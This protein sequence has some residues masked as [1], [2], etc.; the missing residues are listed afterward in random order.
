VFGDDLAARFANGCWLAS[1]DDEA[2]VPPA[3]DELLDDFAEVQRSTPG[4]GLTAHWLERPGQ[5]I[6]LVSE[7]HRAAKAAASWWLHAGDEAQL[8]AL[9]RHLWRWGTLEKTLSSPTEVGK[10]VLGRLRGG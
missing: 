10:A 5:R 2:V 1:A 7:D 3:L 9:A 4:A 6:Y 8:E